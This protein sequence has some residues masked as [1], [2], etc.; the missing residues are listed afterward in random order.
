MILG[1]R[2]FRNARTRGWGDGSSLE[3]ELE[4][5]QAEFITVQTLR[6]VLSMH[7]RPTSKNRLAATMDFA[8]I[9]I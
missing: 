7:F 8:F 6:L 5:K 4:R 1:N 3:H 9:Y 2:L